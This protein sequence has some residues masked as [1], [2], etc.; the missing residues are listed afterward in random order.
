MYKDGKFYCDNSMLTSVAACTT[1]YVMEYVWGWRARAVMV[2]ADA[3][4]IGHVALRLHF[5]GVQREVVLKAFDDLYVPFSKEQLLDDRL[6]HQNVRDVIYVW[7]SRHP[8]ERLP[9]EAIRDEDGVIRAEKGIAVPLISDIVFFALID[10]EARDKAT[11]EILPVDHKTTGSISGWW[12]KKFRL[13]SQQTGYIWAIGQA[14]GTTCGKTYINAIEFSK[15]P[16]PIKRK[17][18][19]HGVNYEECRLEHVKHQLLSTTR[20]AEALE[21]WKTTAIMWARRARELYDK[22]SMLTPEY[23][24][25]VRMNGAFTRACVFCEF[26]DWCQGGRQAAQVERLFVQKPWRPWGQRG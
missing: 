19:T 16:E 23:I 20:S 13:A 14:Y 4:N 9:F 11:G 25:M 10:L 15:L 7:M 21:E 12:A 6:A 17:C 5:E 18:C 3:G 1:Q 8:L 22:M 26:A 2:A 24:S